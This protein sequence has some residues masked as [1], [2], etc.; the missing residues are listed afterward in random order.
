MRFRSLV[1]RGVYTDWYI[2][3][4]ARPTGTT[5]DQC[6]QRIVNDEVPETLANRRVV[7][8]DLGSMVAVTTLDECRT[9]IEGGPVRSITLACYGAAQIA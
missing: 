5:P 2:G 3:P 8:L 4:S 6:W 1:P 9:D 7:A